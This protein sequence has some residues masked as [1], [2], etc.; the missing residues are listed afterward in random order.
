MKKLLIAIL[1]LLCFSCKGKQIDAA[2][3][4]S[5]VVSSFNL[6][7]PDAGEVEWELDKKGGVIIYKAEFSGEDE[8][9]AEFDEHG[10]F[11]RED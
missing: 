11:I 7:Y 9:E 10:N 1:P 2:E 6:R 8:S 5:P 4:P 3:V